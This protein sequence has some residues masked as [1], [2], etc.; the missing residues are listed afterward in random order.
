MIGVPIPNYDDPDA[1][2]DHYVCFIYEKDKKEL[3][4]LIHRLQKV[5][6]TQKLIKY[7]H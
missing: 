5:M 3:H 7:Y 2:Q 6:K 4:Y 1:N